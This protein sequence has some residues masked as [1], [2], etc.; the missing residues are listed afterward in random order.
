MDGQKGAETAWIRGSTR[1]AAA[2]KRTKSLL[3]TFVDYDKVKFGQFKYIFVSETKK[4]TWQAKIG[5]KISKVAHGAQGE[6]GGRQA[7]EEATR[8]KDSPQPGTNKA[9]PRRAKCKIERAE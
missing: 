6:G 3:D 7:A 2:G 1:K 5:R 9:D 8:R 4:A